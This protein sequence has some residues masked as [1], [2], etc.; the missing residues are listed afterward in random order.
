VGWLGKG[1]RAFCFIPQACDYLLLLLGLLFLLLT[2][3]VQEFLTGGA[4]LNDNA[5]PAG[6]DV[7][8]EFR[9]RCYPRN[10]QQR[11]HIATKIP[12]KFIKMA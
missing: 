10:S 12:L 5:S 7:L 6:D 9:H 2:E 11:K 3:L 4:S 8:W 1:S